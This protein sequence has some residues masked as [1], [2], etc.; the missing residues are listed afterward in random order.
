M[1]KTR[2]SDISLREKKIAM[3]KIELLNIVLEITKTKRLEEIS[4][5][6]ICDAAMISEG[7]FFNYFPRKSDILTYFIRLWTIQATYLANK[8]I[9]NTSGLKKIEFVFGCTVNN[10]T[11]GNERIIYEIISHFSM[12]SKSSDI[13]I[14]GISVAEKLVAFPELPDI[15]SQKLYRFDDVFA[16][17]L[18]LAIELGEIPPIKNVNLVRVML[19]SI[20]FG[21]PLALKGHP[22]M[23][24]QMYSEA[25]DALWKALRQS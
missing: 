17:Y 2:I 13:D 16:E 10:L 5:K 25:L 21:V 3:K 1:N 23:I 20:F 6:E 18:K 8:E 24:Q 11:I 12:E 7:T 22:E 9:G 15:A 14:S 4:V 19:G